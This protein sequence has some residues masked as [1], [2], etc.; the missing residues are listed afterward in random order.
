MW[1]ALDRPSLYRGTLLIRKRYPTGHCRR[2]MPRVLGG[3]RF[4][5][6]EVQGYRCYSIVRTHNLR[7]HTEK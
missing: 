4:L 3:A 1:L 7:I 2:P 5:M 6:S